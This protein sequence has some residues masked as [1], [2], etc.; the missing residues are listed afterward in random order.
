M[1]QAVP[2]TLNEGEG[3]SPLRED[4][5]LWLPLVAELSAG[6]SPPDLVDAV[7]ARLNPPAAGW[8]GPK[9]PPAATGWSGS[10][11]L[12]AED[13]PSAVRLE[14]A[15]EGSDRARRDA[16]RRAAVGRLRA[17]VG[18]ACLLLG[19]GAGWF[20]WRPDT[21]PAGPV[22]LRSLPETP[23]RTEFPRGPF[24][25]S[26]RD[27]LRPQPA[28]HATAGQVTSLSP[29]QVRREALENRPPA[30][31][32]PGP[33]TTGPTSPGMT[34]DL[35]DPAGLVA[36]RRPP[37][38]PDAPPGPLTPEGKRLDRSPWGDPMQPLPPEAGSLGSDEEMTT[39]IDA[40]LRK[41]WADLGLKPSP[42]ATEGEWVRRLF[43][44]LLGRIPTVDEV[45]SF[46]DDRAPQKR[47][48]LV[49][50][51]TESE[52]YQAEFV[53]HW[54]TLWTNLLIG[55]SG[56]MTPQT[57]V[58]RLALHQWLRN[59]FARNLPAD[60]FTAALLVAEGS[61]RPGT[62][63]FRGEANFLLAHLGAEH[64]PATNR[65]GQVFLG[66]RL[67]CMQCHHHPFN[68]WKQEQFWGLNA[69][70][71]QAA[72]ETLSGIPGGRRLVD[73]DFAGGGN[74]ADEAEVY[75]EARGGLLKAAYPTFFD[76]T[77][78]SP[79][80]RIEVV[81]RRVEL[82]KL[83][84]SSR[85]F[86]LA[87]TNRVW[88]HFLGY[89]LCNPI[90]DMGPH[91]PP[92]HPEL[93]N[94]LADAFGTVGFDRRRLIRWIVLSEAYGLSS[95]IVPENSADAPETGET[96]QFAR[97]YLRQMRP[98]DLYASMHVALR[99]R[100]D[101]EGNEDDRER[102]R[103]EWLRQYVIDFETDENDE[104][105]LFDGSITQS[106]LMMNGDLMA[107]AI[108]LESGAFLRRVLDQ[109]SDDRK[110]LQQLYLAALARLP[111][112]QE[113]AIAQQLRQ[114]RRGDVATV[115]QDLWWAL[116]NSN[117]FIV[118]H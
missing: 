111:T 16:V 50:K 116:L 118:N 115:L 10:N 73:R 53:R 72:G 56:G 8:S 34:L 107:Q 67:G 110:K 40:A 91:N 60:R 112:P 103:F 37:W 24:D 30:S 5:A 22:V 35:P 85:A 31:T 83:L 41:R 17:C 42:P 23:R 32:G 58:D 19:I 97:F 93:F 21:F 92:S 69:F 2:R 74:D 80:G 29:E 94:R 84:T 3:R 76:G 87:E 70:F 6:Q 90:D 114:A 89:G 9:V 113:A 4:D 86:R 36:P 105:T 11:L 71:K 44:D 26:A 48:R 59:G 45:K 51:L 96:P 61:N 46:L 102:R 7:L 54:A 64:V 14:P 49:A 55:R 39:R 52:A 13:E 20:V 77:R 101:D 28:P 95:R 98:E 82:A 99:Q 75:F 108:G 78:I 109:P 117:E 43:L 15:P 47:S 1:S 68:D 104:T 33:T 18:T 66:M 63:D 57:G 25:G 62:E 81:R 38:D 27:P 88:A 100:P 79:S 65:V 12:S 106:L